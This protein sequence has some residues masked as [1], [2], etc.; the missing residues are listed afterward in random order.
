MLKEVVDIFINMFQIL[1][2]YV[3]AYGCPTR[4]VVSGFGNQDRGFEP[5]RSRRT[6]LAKKS[7]ACLP[8][9]GK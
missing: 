7:T 2:R 8:S 9:E 5:G 1:P 4:E 6:F 3:S